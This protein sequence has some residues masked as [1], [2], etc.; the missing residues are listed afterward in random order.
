M[1]GKSPRAVEGELAPSVLEI[2]DVSASKRKYSD[3]INV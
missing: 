2:I 1:R 3:G